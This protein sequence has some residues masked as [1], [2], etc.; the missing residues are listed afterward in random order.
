MKKLLTFLL[1]LTTLAGF[2]Q[3][4]TI[5]VG[6][7]GVGDAD[8]LGGKAPSFYVDTLS[9][10]FQPENVIYVTQESDF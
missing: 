4:T 2:S 7:I 10:A 9:A 5:T 6:G 1:T 3:S 8:S